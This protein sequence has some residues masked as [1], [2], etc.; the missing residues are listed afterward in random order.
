CWLGAAFPSYS[1]P[2]MGRVLCQRTTATGRCSPNLMWFPNSALFFSRRWYSRKALS[3][4]D[5]APG[6][7]P[8]ARA[9]GIGPSDLS[10]L[11]RRRA[12]IVAG[13]RITVAI[14]GAGT[15]AARTAHPAGTGGAGRRSR[16]RHRPP[17][18]DPADAVDLAR[19]PDRGLADIL[20][21]GQD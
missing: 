20:R 5:A 2:A 21:P 1:R 7:K 10:R 14:S 8:A 19:P 12:P 18:Y 15:R 17:A 11:N 6:R 13:R 3:I 16:S 4:H 9:F